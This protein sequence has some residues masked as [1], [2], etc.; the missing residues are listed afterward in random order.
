MRIFIIFLA[1][2]INFISADSFVNEDYQSYEKS[3][4]D[5]NVLV[6]VTSHIIPVD[7]SFVQNKNPLIISIPQDALNPDTNAKVISKGMYD[8]GNYTIFRSNDDGITF[9]RYTKNK[10]NQYARMAPNIYEVTHYGGQLYKIEPTPPNVTECSL[11]ISRTF[12][13]AR[14]SSAQLMLNLDSV[15][16]RGIAKILLECPKLPDY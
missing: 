4:E 11:I 3:K 12:E 7:A 2:F 1:I 16:N 9:Y 15:P 14:T 5:P 13:A 6:F 10:T 8:K